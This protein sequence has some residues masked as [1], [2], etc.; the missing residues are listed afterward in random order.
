MHESRTIGYTL[1]VEVGLHV[2]NVNTNPLKI[3]LVLDVRHENEGRDDTRALRCAQLGADL[4]VPNVVCRCEKCANCALR[5]SQQSRFL[6]G[7][8]VCV[9]SRRA[10][11]LPVNLGGIAEVLVDALDVVERVESVGAGLARG[12]GYARV[13]GMRHERVTT[14]EAEGAY[15]TVAIYCTLLAAHSTKYC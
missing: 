7:A 11:R 15:T 6:S 9:D 1:G 5:H 10:L 13:E 3:D 14:A 8:G 2:A 4:A 12:A